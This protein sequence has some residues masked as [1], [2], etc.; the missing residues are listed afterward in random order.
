MNAELRGR[1]DDAR[2]RFANIEADPDFEGEWLVLA[3]WELP[4]PTTPDEGWPLEQLDGYC[5]LLADRLTDLAA[6]ECLFRTS[7][8]L[9]EDAKL[10]NAIPEPV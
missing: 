4:D 6:T 10:G 7:A 1:G 2:I 3:T 8:E 9:A 5:E